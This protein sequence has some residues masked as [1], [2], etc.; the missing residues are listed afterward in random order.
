MESRRNVI[1]SVLTLIGSSL[2][3]AQLFSGEVSTVLAETTGFNLLIVT[4]F[5]RPMSQGEWSELEAKFMDEGMYT[6][7]GNMFKSGEI[8]FQEDSFQGDKVEWRVSF[9]DRQSYL[10]WQDGV[11]NLKLIDAQA[12]RDLGFE[13]ETFHT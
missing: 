13:I 4:K 12:Y 10:K 5:P 3:P 8:L 11:Q 1:R 2:L 9:R 6:F 7:V